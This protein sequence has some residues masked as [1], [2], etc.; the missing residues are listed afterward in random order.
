MM[1]GQRELL[2]PSGTPEADAL[3]MQSEAAAIAGDMHALN[4]LGV[5]AERDGDFPRAAA[6][7]SMTLDIWREWMPDAYNF[8]PERRNKR[9][10]ENNCHRSV[11]LLL[12]TER[13]AFEAS[14]KSVSE[15]YNSGST[16]FGFSERFIDGLAHVFMTRRFLMERLHAFAPFLSM[17]MAIVILQFFSSFLALRSESDIVAKVFFD[18]VSRSLGMGVFL[19]YL[20]GG[21]PVRGGWTTFKIAMFFLFIVSLEFLAKGLFSSILSAL[22]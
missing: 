19:L 1:W 8:A 9:I 6:L 3:L 7:H 2:P 11:A 14:L 15:Q 10:L 20:A 13:E 17:A 4:I 16:H 5:M 12:D 21:V 22:A 18:G